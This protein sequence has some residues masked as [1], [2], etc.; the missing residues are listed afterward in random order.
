MKTEKKGQR[1]ELKLEGG[2][3]EARLQRPTCSGRCSRG[4]WA[5]VGRQQRWTTTGEGRGA[6]VIM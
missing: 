2:E 1:V 4:K 5:N 6:H 3:V